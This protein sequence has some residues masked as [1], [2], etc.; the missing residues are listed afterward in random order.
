MSKKVFQLTPD[1]SRAVTGRKNAVVTAGAGTGKTRVLAERFCHIMEHESVGIDQILTLTFTNKATTEM[2]ERIY[3]T[4][5]GVENPHIQSELK[6]FHAASIT[7]FDSFCR[8]L[9]EG[10]LVSMGYP[11][12]IV[13]DQVEIT[14]GAKNLIFSFFLNRKR[15]RS[16]QSLRRAM[17]T[18]TLQE[19]IF[20][21]LALYHMHPSR[22]IDFRVAYRQYLANLLKVL[23]DNL[24]LLGEMERQ[25][26]LATILPDIQ[27]IPHHGEG[28]SAESLG[29]YTLPEEQLQKAIEEDILEI[30]TPHEFQKLRDLLSKQRAPRGFGDQKKEALAALNQILDIYSWYAERGVSKRLFTLLEEFQEVWL[31]EKRQRG[32]LSF[33]DTLYLS[34]DLLKSNFQLRSEYN[35]RFRYI[36]VDEV[37]DNNQ[38]QWELLFLLAAP[39]TYKKEAIPLVSELRPEVLFCVGDKKQSIYRFRGAAPDIFTQLGQ[40]LVQAGG[41]QHVLRDNFRTE[42]ALIHWFNRVFSPKIEDY[43]AIVPG[44]SSGGDT[45]P[46]VLLLG[47][48]EK[49]LDIDPKI[50]RVRQEAWEVGQLLK[51]MVAEGAIVRSDSGEKP[52]SYDDMAVLFKSTTQQQHFEEVFK[53]LDIPYSVESARTLYLEGPVTDAVCMLQFALQPY[54]QGYLARVLRSPY[55]GC[56]DTTVLRLLLQNKPF[57]ELDLSDLSR[58]EREKVLLAKQLL[59]KI[60]PLIDR[61]SHSAVIRKLWY[62]GGYRYWLLKDTKTHSYL[63]H[64]YYLQQM[65]MGADSRGIPMYQLLQELMEDFGS[66]TKVEE[67]PL[68]PVQR[69]V[70]LMTIHKSKGLE[71]PVVVIPQLT[72]TTTG[73]ATPLCMVSDR[74]GITI[75]PG[76]PKELGSN[77]FAASLKKQE[78]EENRAELLRLFYVAVTRA[79]SHIIF[80]GIFGKS[81]SKVSADSLY[82]FLIESVDEMESF[83][84]HVDIQQFQEVKELPLSTYRNQGRS[85]RRDPSQV[86]NSYYPSPAIQVH[87]PDITV[88]GINTLYYESLKGK[89]VEGELRKLAIDEIVQEQSFYGKFGTLCHKIM[90]LTLEGKSIPPYPCDEAYWRNYYDTTEWETILSDAHSLVSAYL[91]NHGDRL[92]RGRKY[93]EESIIISYESLKQQ[94]KP[95][96]GRYTTD[97]L[98]QLLQEKSPNL[99]EVIIGQVDL[100]IELEDRVE[101]IDFKTN[102]QKTPGQ[103]DMQM[104]LY[105]YGVEQIFSKPVTVELVYLREYLI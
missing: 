101:V 32:F 43:D 104:A 6:R 47:G 46:T 98:D 81:S 58:K 20:L 31:K 24:R 51:K 5:S 79:K 84:E 12:Q 82:S 65:A 90:E 18:D 39:A 60:V 37:Q 72:H 66:N 56:D 45:L 26:E 7:T 55:F 8:S 64:Y 2:Q 34:I 36:M 100:I 68:L 35:R 40:E 69:G 1:Q 17:G 89:G 54:H 80:S 3:Q 10:E 97:K 48:R 86:K 25:G 61:A 105:A 19:E 29:L 53:R 99:P 41:E 70:S 103:Y 9:I 91:Q 16:L 94:K 21:P 28:V 71:F 59:Q 74:Y 23:Q 22:P 27:P 33:S 62:Q 14:Q 4:L 78:Q 102:R 88:V 83:G 95:L 15:D 77:P 57:D 75:T 87:D 67:N 92:Q 49:E 11:T 63:E 76:N 13:Q 93:T 30:G 96:F 42:P 38:S 52:A 73:G 85:K 50:G 44:T